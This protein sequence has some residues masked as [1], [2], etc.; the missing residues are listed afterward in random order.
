MRM[1]DD[2]SW[3]YVK[4]NETTRIPRR[5]IFLDTEA[6]SDATPN[7]QIQRWRLAVACFQRSPKGKKH[8]ERWAQFSDPV[9]L[10]RAVSEHTG[11]DD[12]T[13][14]WAHNLAYDVRISEA[15]TILPDLGW[16]LVSHNLAPRGTW[17]QWKKG[18]ASLVMVDSVAIFPTTLAQVGKTVGLG[19][20]DLPSFDDSD[21]AWFERC[22]ADVRILATAVNNYL[23]WLE[24]EDLGNWQLTGAGQSWAAFRHRFMTHRLLVHGDDTALAAERRAMW[25]GRCEAYWHGTLDRQVV[26]EWDLT[27]AYA[28]IARDISV[29]VRYLGPM[30]QGYDWRGTVESPNVALLANVQITTDTPVVPTEIDGRIVW[31]VGTFKTT[32]WDSEIKAA[33]RAGADIQVEAGWLY[34]LRPALKAWADWLISQLE[35]T[36]GMVPAW[37]CIILKHWARALIGRMAMTYTQWEEYATTDDNKVRRSTV[38]DR[39]SR[40][41]YEIMQVGGTIWR[42]TGRVEWSQSMPMV[43][44]YIQAACRVRL[45]EIMQALPEKVVLYVDTDSLLTTDKHMATMETVARSAIGHGLR[46]KRS[47]DGFAI[48]GP[49]QVRTGNQLRVSGVPR[50]AQRVAR[51]T[52]SGEIWE[53]LSVSLR[54]AQPGRIVIR[55]RTWTLT[56]VDRRRIGYGIGWTN[57]ITVGGTANDHKAETRGRGPDRPGRPGRPGRRRRTSASVPGPAGPQ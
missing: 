22:T 18:K 11:K 16:R 46:L 4:R 17:L 38:Y 54:N 3:H 20:P 19:K 1:T 31:P 9:G 48:Y 41:E 24:S 33:L 56:G 12:R 36:S 29:P 52:Y 13:I 51:H 8:Y 28:R 55:N 34:R 15:F 40:E 6:R 32:L 7:G 42:D 10:W 37:R 5:H 25:T 39:D 50:R 53:S 27:L 47:W 2:R 35:D 45:W 43:T 14:L 44:G 30:P 21:S 57:P 23:A 49:R 26:H